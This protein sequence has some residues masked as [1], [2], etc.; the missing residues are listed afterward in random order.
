MYLNTEIVFSDCLHVKLYKCVKDALKGD[1]PKH[2][3]FLEEF[4]GLETGFT[5]D[6]ELH[7]LAI[8]CHKQI[9]VFSFDT[10]DTLIKFE[11]K[12]RHA[13]GE[14]MLLFNRIL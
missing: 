10:R 3:F 13:I 9:T 11:I 14:G 12:I 6:K 8:L 1:K 5:Y 7:V 4:Y 2:D